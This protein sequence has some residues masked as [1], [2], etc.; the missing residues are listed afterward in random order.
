[1]NSTL[2]EEQLL[3]GFASQ[4]VTEEYLGLWRRRI[5][6]DGDGNEDK[7]T[8]RFWMQTSDWHADLSIAPERPDFTKASNL[9]ECS[10][11]QLHWL[12][13]NQ[14]GFAG[15]TRLNDDLCYWDRQHDSSLR[16]TADIG[17]M[18][19]DGNSVHESGVLCDLYE[20]WERM[21]FSADGSEFTIRSAA[22]SSNSAST[23]LLL[24]RGGYFMYMRDRPTA[25]TT[26][27]A[28]QRRISEGC[29]TRSDLERFA[30]FE[31]SLGCIDNNSWRVLHSTLPWRENRLFS[32]A[33]PPAG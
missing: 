2:S 29:A 30:D 12:C 5:Y 31:M 20:H 3:P 24:V 22:L 4:G 17:R 10:N 18:R 21:P 25:S 19:F 16:T 6:I 15:V 14:Q 23:T 28:I 8:I 7:S 33:S 32:L 11:E 27:L 1:M 13:C 26:L 9:T